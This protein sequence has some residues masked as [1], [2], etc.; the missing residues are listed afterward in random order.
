MMIMILTLLMLIVCS[1]ITITISISSNPPISSN[2]LGN[3]VFTIIITN[4][5]TYQ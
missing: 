3:D 5:N 2:N 1:S 4:I